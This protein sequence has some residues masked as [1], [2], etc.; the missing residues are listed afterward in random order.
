MN[1]DMLRTEQKEIVDKFK[2]M[3][4]PLFGRKVYWFW[5]GKG[6]WGKSLT[7]MYMIDHMKAFVVAGKNN[8]ILCGITKHIEE[9]GEC[10]PIVIF[11]IPRC[12][13]G[14]TSYQAI[15]NLKNGYFYSGKY[16]SG[17]CRFNR[18]H[19]ICFS[20]EKPEDHNL[21]SDRWIIEELIHK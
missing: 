21:S 2:E 17:M 18:P 5:E 15:E 14:H 8:D 6:S 13:C 9:Q 16:E 20:N 3:E 19:I 7:C 1:Y 12:N 11:D 4:D 10:P